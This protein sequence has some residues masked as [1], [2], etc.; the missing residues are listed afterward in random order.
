[1]RKKGF[2]LIEL[3]VVIAIIAILAAILFPVFAQAREKA[4]AITCTSYMKQMGIAFAMYRQDY[5]GNHPPVWQY[6]WGVDDAPHYWMQM[7][8]PYVKTTAAWICPSGARPSKDIDP[9]KW[10][11]WHG[12]TAAGAAGYRMNNYASGAQAGLNESAV[13]FPAE[14]FVVVDGVRAYSDNGAWV[15]ETIDY[16]GW[17]NAWTEPCPELWSP[18]QRDYSF[19][20]TDVSD[21]HSKGY[22]VLFYDSHVKWR[23]WGSSKPREWYP[24]ARETD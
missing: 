8:Y 6:W 21:R 24:D 7:I 19:T 14:L 23:K 12:C 4:R 22:N 9:S 16:P 5:D 2:T 15:S 3:L 17:T 13:K 10:T 18:N 20:T 11:G 1:M